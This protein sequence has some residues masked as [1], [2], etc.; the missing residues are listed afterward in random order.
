[1][2]ELPALPSHEGLIAEEWNWTLSEIQSYLNKRQKI[3]VGC[4]YDTPD[5]SVCLFLHA[6]KG[7]RL[8]NLTLRF[9]VAGQNTVTVYWGD[10]TSSVFAN[11]QSGYQWYNPSKTDYAAVQED[12]DLCVRITGGYFK[13]G[14]NTTEYNLFNGGSQPVLTRAYIG[15]KCTLT[16]GIFKNCFHLKHIAFSK[17]VLFSNQIRRPFERCYSL[18]SV[19][20]P[21]G[22]VRIDEYFAGYCNDLHTVALPVSVQNLLRGAFQDCHSLE[23]VTLSDQT[24]TFKND[25]FYDCYDLMSV[26]IPGQSTKIESSAFSDCYSLPSVKI[27]GT[28]TSI[29]SR[30][31][32]NCTNLYEVDLTAYTDPNSLPTITVNSFGSTPTHL[33]FYVAN[34]EM[35]SAFSAATNWSSYASQFQVRGSNV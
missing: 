1:M 18:V 33:V 3:I 28:V 32:E 30:A 16:E 19:T 8:D 25:V 35:L 23:N 9:G 5:G 2:T 10:G 14:N 24:T 17:D 20:V 15:S 29:G 6:A 21:R 12:M 4:N 27:P 31:F 26:E 13:L 22:S 34:Q 11:T 7:T